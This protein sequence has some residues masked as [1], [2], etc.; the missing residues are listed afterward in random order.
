MTSPSKASPRGPE[1]FIFSSKSVGVG[2]AAGPL[3]QKGVRFKAGWTQRSC[4]AE[5]AVGFQ[6]RNGGKQSSLT[7]NK[8]FRAGFHS[9]F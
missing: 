5:V 9:V 8:E 7:A 2:M 1:N 3:F 4:E 6:V